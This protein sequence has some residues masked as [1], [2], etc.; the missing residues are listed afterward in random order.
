M[1]KVF[2]TVGLLPFIVGSALAS[3]PGQSPSSQDTTPVENPEP[4]QY[5]EVVEVAGTTKHEL[6]SRAS[7]WFAETFNSANDVL[8]LKDESEGRLVGKGVIWYEPKGITGSEPIR[9]PVRFT[10]KVSVK[11]GRYKYEFC[12]FMH[13]GNPAATY[14]AI[15]FGLVTTSSTA[16]KVGVGAS[17][18]WRVKKWN[19]IK[20]TID[21]HVAALVLSLKAAMAAGAAEDDW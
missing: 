10:T 6:Y 2:I 13:E 12:D 18:G 7:L 16:P 9:G 14:G 8:Q 4:L 17:K 21:T 11:D 5:S 3:E 20:A 15:S 1:R 19:E